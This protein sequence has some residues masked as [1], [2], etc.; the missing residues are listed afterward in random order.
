M[1]QILFRTFLA[2]K[3]TICPPKRCVPRF[4]DDVFCFR[5]SVGSLW[6]RR[7]LKTF[8]EACKSEKMNLVDFHN[9]GAHWF[10]CKNRFFFLGRVHC[11]LVFCD[12]ILIF[13]WNVSTSSIFGRLHPLKEGL[14]QSKQVSFGFQVFWYIL[15]MTKVV[16]R[17]SKGFHYYKTDRGPPYLRMYYIIIIFTHQPAHP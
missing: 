14:L 5:F 3:P 9:L 15:G 12:W 6:A 8:W 10:D 13:I 11:P 2:K 4:Q 1:F 17:G 16:L 7:H